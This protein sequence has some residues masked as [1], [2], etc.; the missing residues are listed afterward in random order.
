[1]DARGSIYEKPV[2][3]IR[4]QIRHAFSWDKQNGETNW[5]K[6]KYTDKRI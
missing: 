6:R 2:I 1:M 5:C 3:Y 4:R